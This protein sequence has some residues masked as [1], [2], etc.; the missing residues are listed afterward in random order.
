MYFGN[1]DPMGKTLRLRDDD[2]TDE[3]VKVTGVFKD[4]P[5][6]THLKFDVLF[7]YNSL[8]ARGDWAI[9]RYREGW[10][11]KEMYTF[12]QLKPADDPKKIEA[13]FPAIVAK[14]KPELKESREKQLLGLQPL[15]DIH[16]YS[17][18]VKSRNQMEMQK[19]FSSW[20]LI[21]HICNSNRMDQLCKSFNGR[22]L[23]RA[24]EMDIRKVIG[25]VKGQLIAQFLAE[26]ALVNLLSVLIAW[27]LAFLFL[28]SFNKLSGL[29]LD[30]IILEPVLVYIFISDVVVGWQFAFRFLSCPGPF[31]FQAD[32]GVKRKIEK[33]QSGY[34]V[35][36]GARGNAIHGFHRLDCGHLHC[37]S[38]GK[39][40][41][42]Q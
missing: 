8:Y 23:E 34:P 15:K 27:G 17:D 20:V 29:T 33:H 16:L 41:D 14:Y 1:E 28:S 30:L 31:F 40:H 42:R 3:L 7:S 24:R 36:Q 21:R 39:I 32:Y 19:Q 35:T 38:P 12:V 18:L 22:A 25:A 9:Q 26:A 11:R 13:K 4:L 5:P 2:F 10:R 6:N 37:L